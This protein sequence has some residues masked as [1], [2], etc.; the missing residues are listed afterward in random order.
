MTGQFL[1]Q[2][3]RW[4]AA[5]CCVEVNSSQGLPIPAKVYGL[6]WAEGNTFTHL[7]RWSTENKAPELLTLPKLV[8][9]TTQKCKS[10]LCTYMVQGHCH[11]TEFPHCKII[12]LCPFRRVWASPQNS[13]EKRS[14]IRELLKKS[15][16]IID[17][18]SFLALSDKPAK[19]V[20]DEAV[21]HHRVHPRLTGP[22]SNTGS[23]WCLSIL[24]GQKLFR[25]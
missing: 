14:K 23:H 9:A 5:F 25:I 2:R 11:P 22:S 7:R 6:R 17:F 10:M 18:W 15:S 8:L 21:W 3:A 16:W 13:K 24:R 1:S 19:K 4:Q 20:P 12:H